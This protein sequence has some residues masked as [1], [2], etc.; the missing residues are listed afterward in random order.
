MKRFI[1]VKFLGIFCAMLLTVALAY[2]V[3]QRVNQTNQLVDTAQQSARTASRQADEIKAL[4]SEVRALRMASSKRAKVASGERDGLKTQLYLLTKFLR[5]HGLEVPSS[6]TPRT[7]QSTPPKSAPAPQ[8]GKSGT[9][10]TNP[11]P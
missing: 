5:E 11:K 7:G 3:V 8:P 1:D 10:R 4:N 6:V 2:V 9:R